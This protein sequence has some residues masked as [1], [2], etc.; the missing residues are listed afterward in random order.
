MPVTH[1]FVV[2]VQNAAQRLDHYLADQLPDLS[3][4]QIK[5]LIEDQQVLVSGR[6]TKAGEKLKGGET[7]LVTVPDPTPAEP[8]AQD[9]PLDILYEDSHLIV[10]N[11]PAGLVVHPAAGHASGT[12]VNALLYH[13]DDLA[14]IGGELRP[15][16]VHRLDKETSGV[17]VAAKNDATHQHLARQF[18]AHSISRRYLALVHGLVQ[19]DE[20]EIDRPI[21]RHAV[22]R[23]KMSSRG[24]G[25]RRAVTRWRVLKRYDRD[26]LTLL[27]LTLETGR[28]H[29][30][31]VHFADLNL[32]LVGDEV[33]GSSGRTR[34]I[35]DTELRR[36]VQKL[37]RQALH[38]RLLG[39]IHPANGDAMEFASSPPADLQEILAYLDRKYQ[40]SDQG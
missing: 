25:G 28:T 32:P 30:I 20:G 5:K 36:L 1:Q 17:M 40:V 2:P 10:I 23:K 12:L 16:I 3:R 9:I 19:N 7:L 37:G 13:C 27:E 38:A 35:N 31:R 34:A 29:Q 14:G 24:T 39:F 21:G 4:S 6:A 11:K 33:Y 22:E 8:V 18:K 15:G 26:R